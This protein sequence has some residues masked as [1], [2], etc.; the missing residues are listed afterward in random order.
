EV[1]THTRIAEKPVSV[2]SIAYRM[3]KSLRIAPDARIL[4]VGA[5][6]TNK[7]FSKYLRKHGSTNFTVFNRTFEKAGQ[8][9]AELEGKALPLDALPEFG[10]GFDVLITCTAAPGPIITPAIFRSLLA[11]ETSEKTVV[12]L[13][14][15]PDTSEE[16]RTAPGVHFIGM[17]Q[18]QGTGRRNMN[19]RYLELEAA[20]KR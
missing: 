3:L 4:L 11:G 17:E 14:L 6:Q 10:K 5:G 13:A 12:D 1:Y 9:A 18:L 16:L 15:P 7:L 19:E 20:D 8:L 2:V